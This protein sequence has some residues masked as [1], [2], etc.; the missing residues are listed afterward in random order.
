MRSYNIAVI[1]IGKITQDQHLPVIAKNPRF[2]LAATVSQRGLAEP[3]V[4]SFKTTAEMLTA[5]PEVDAVAICTPPY[6]RH[7]IA[8][9]S[10][11]AGKHLLLEKPTTTTT[12]ELTDLIAHAAAKKRVIFT[13]WHS[14]YNPAVD[15]A[16]RLLAKAGIRRLEVEW[17]EDVRRWH[18]GQEWIWQA[19][20]FGVCDPGINALSIVTRIMP[21]PVFVQ[22]AELTMPANRDTPIAAKLAFAMP[23]AG[24]GPQKLTAEFDW[25]Q[26]GP[27]TWNITVETTDGKVLALT[28]GGSKL[29][30]D[31]K[32]TVDVKMQEYERIYDRF[33]ELLDTGTNEIDEAPLQLMADAFLVGKRV[34]TEPFVW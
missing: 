15:E 13:T 8:R 18:P 5:L 32:P 19:G 20:G 33:A 7:A 26:T 23:D 10:L 29:A 11:D 24:D 17:K 14:Q 9:Q 1:G 28:E 27:Q 12:A 34:E 6:A 25:R 2:T 30:V 4:P 21:L 3:G 22:Q 16:K 31:G